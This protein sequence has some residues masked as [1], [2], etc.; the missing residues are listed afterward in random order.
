[1]VNESSMNTER[2]IVEL[3]LEAGK[4]QSFEAF[5]K[6][7]K[8]QGRLFHVRARQDQT[9]NFLHSNFEFV[10]WFQ[11]GGGLR[12]PNALSMNTLHRG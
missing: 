8:F 3:M 12:P 1:M 2:V 10:S 4:F 9:S 7:K 5:D 6:L 11:G